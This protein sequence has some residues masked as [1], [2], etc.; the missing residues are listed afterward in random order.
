VLRLLL[1]NLPPDLTGDGCSFLADD[2]RVLER[3]KEKNSTGLSRSYHVI[4]IQK[5][6]EGELER[7][8]LTQEHQ[9]LFIAKHRKAV[10]PLA[11]DMILL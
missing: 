7:A 10:M 9:P 3:E 11:Y 8:G 1:N 4:L 5:S 6:V 2:R